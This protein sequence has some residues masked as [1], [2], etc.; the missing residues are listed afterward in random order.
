MDE[1]LQPI[2]FMLASSIKPGDHP[3]VSYLPVLIMSFTY[4]SPLINVNRINKYFKNVF[5]CKPQYFEYIIQS[6]DVP[7]IK[8]YTS[9]PMMRM[10]FSHKFLAV[11][12]YITRNINKHRFCSVTEI[13]S[14]NSELFF[15][16][17]DEE[18]EGKKYIDLPLNNEMTMVNEVDEIYC[19][20]KFEKA[21]E[22]SSENESKKNMKVNRNSHYIIVLS[23]KMNSDDCTGKMNRFVEQCVR[24]YDVYVSS[25]QK[26]KTTNHTSIPIYIQK[27]SMRK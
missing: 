17:D 2:L 12:H 6:H 26:K 5:H 15:C 14:Y 23:I 1:R 20:Y 3:L 27:R 24:E 7:V 19:Q 4:L 25:T 8:N 22:D 13:M 16:R 18:D 10:Q 9:V 21:E 11:S